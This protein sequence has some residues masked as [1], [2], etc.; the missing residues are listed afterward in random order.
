MYKIINLVFRNLPTLINSGIAFTSNYLYLPSSQYYPLN[1]V[2][3]AEYLLEE[4]RPDL[5][6]MVLDKLRPENVR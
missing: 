3:T 5:I 2:L 6:D 1:G 4:F